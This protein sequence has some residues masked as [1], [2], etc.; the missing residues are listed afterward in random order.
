V[1]FQPLNSEAVKAI[2]LRELD[3]IAKREGLLR[4][5]VRMAW[6][7]ALVEHLAGVG[8]DPRYGARPLQR[9]VEREVVA[10]LARWLLEH[11]VPEG[12][13]IR[14]DWVEGKCVFGV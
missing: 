14:A 11:F 3:A 13:V 2:A 7:D 8:F 6:S 12:G 5:G 10:P 9:A 1:T 4:S